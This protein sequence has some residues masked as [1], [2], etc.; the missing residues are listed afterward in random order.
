MLTFFSARIAKYYFP[1]TT[2]GGVGWSSFK[3]VHLPFKYK[4][5]S[6]SA[7]IRAGMVVAVG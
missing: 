4:S 6:G 1:N 5:I 3:N 2:H 7:G